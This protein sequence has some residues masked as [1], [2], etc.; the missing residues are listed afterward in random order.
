MAHKPR[1]KLLKYFIYFITSSYL[2]YKSVN[3]PTVFCHCTFN[4]FHCTSTV[5][6]WWVHLSCLFVKPKRYVWVNC[7]N[8][9]K[10]KR[11]RRQRQRARGYSRTLSASTS[12]FYLSQ[13]LENFWNERASHGCRWFFLDVY[14]GI[15][16]Y[17][18]RAKGDG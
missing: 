15:S 16:A 10:K 17:L 3:T 13:C 5:Q 1:S 9:I 8:Q 11:K 18:N 12:I 14:G 4:V 7:E 2:I 6:F